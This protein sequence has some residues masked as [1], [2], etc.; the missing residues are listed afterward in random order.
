MAANVEIKIRNIY[1]DRI[2][3]AEVTE[4]LDS[5]YANVKSLEDIQFLVQYASQIFPEEPTMANGMS[6]IIIISMVQ[7]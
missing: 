7:I 1:F 6:S 5:I 4:L 2:E 3:R